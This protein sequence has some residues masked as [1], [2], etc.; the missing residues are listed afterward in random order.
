M[1]SNRKKNNVSVFE[2]DPDDDFTNSNH[3]DKLKNKQRSLEKKNNLKD[4]QIRQEL[5]IV[6]IE[7]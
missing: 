7:Q 5:S 1:K 6:E 2:C 3:D 4:K